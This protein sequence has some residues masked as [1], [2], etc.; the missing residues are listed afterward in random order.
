MW[1]PNG[2]GEQKLYNLKVTWEDSRNNEVTRKENRIM[3]HEKTVR[4]GFRTVELVQ[5]ILRKF[6]RILKSDETKIHFDLNFSA[7]GLTFYFKIN[8]VAMFMKGSNWIPS[9][10]LPEESANKDRGLHFYS[11]IY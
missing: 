11:L 1:W 10:I 7:N 2:Y 3:G 6:N 4:I 9:H 5:D 8:G